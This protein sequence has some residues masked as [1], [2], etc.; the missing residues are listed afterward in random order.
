MSE[1]TKSAGRMWPK[2]GAEIEYGNPLLPARIRFRLPTDAEWRSFWRRILR[3]AL[4]GE[5]SAKR[6]AGE[7]Y[8]SLAVKGSPTLDDDEANWLT[9][10]LVRVDWEPEALPGGGVALKGAAFGGL[11]VRL[12]CRTPTLGELH[13]AE[14]ASGETDEVYADLARKWVLSA[15]GYEA[16]PPVYHLS[17]AVDTL[18]AWARR[19]MTE[20]E[21]V[22]FFGDT[23]PGA[24]PEAA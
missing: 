9:G 17:S 1:T 19:R 14:T 6:L 5:E 10:R 11:A 21:E 22:V 24:A 23:T 4:A 16:E 3:A 15:E 2:A 13:K 12:T 20:G 18:A 7:F 8:E